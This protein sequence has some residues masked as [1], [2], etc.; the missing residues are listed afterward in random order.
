MMIPDRKKISTIIMARM[1]KKPDV[2]VKPEEDL[3]DEDPL[4]IVAQELLSAL[5]QKSVMGIKD[6]LRSFFEEYSL[7]QSKEE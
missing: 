1:D 7:S 4:D 6:A 3:R 5:E 2:A